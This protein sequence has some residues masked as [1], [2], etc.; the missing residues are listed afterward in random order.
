MNATPTPIFQNQYTIS[1]SLGSSNQQ[2][3]ACLSSHFPS[4]PQS[5]PIT[6]YCISSNCSK[7][8]RYIHYPTST[9]TTLSDLISHYFSQNMIVNNHLQY[10]VLIHNKI[11]HNYETLIA[12]L[13]LTIHTQIEIIF[14]LNGGA[15]SSSC[16]SSDSSISRTN[17]SSDDSSMHLDHLIYSNNPSPIS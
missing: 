5:I 15:K 4:L 13:N 2:T 14:L 12:D 17:F 8:L 16:S 1:T 3:D 6:T 10:A 7:L 11:V 9:L